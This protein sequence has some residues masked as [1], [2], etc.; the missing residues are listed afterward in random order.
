[1]KYAD[2]I[3]QLHKAILPEG[4]N[5]KGAVIKA[6]GKIQIEIF[7]EGDKVIIDFIGTLPQVSYQKS[8]F[9]LL[10]P[11]FTARLTKIELGPTSGKLFPED[12]PLGYEFDYE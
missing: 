5:I 11:K 8:I 6:F 9:G 3:A 10:K 2:V 7:N 4:V 12:F 1:M